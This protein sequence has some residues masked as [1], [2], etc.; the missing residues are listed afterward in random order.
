MIFIAMLFLV[1]IIMKS[2]TKYIVCCLCLFVSK[3]EYCSKV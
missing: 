2:Y 1:I 3:W